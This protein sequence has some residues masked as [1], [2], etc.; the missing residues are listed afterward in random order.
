VI[1][2]DLINEVLI[3]LREDTITVDWSGH[4][5]TPSSGITAYQKVI[6]SLINDAKRNA[7]T[8]HDWFILRDTID[9]STVSTTRSY[10]LGSG[11]ELK[12]LDVICQET[13]SPLTQVSRKYMNSVKYPTAS[14]GDPRYYAFD[15]SDASNNLKVEFDPTPDSVQTISFDVVKYQDDLKS[16][17]DVVKIP[18]R[19]VIL[20]A[21]ARAIAER[22]EDGG[23]ISSAVAAEAREALVM[24]I[25][26]D[27]SNASFE[28]DWVVT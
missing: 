5:N 24:A 28:R 3:R 25:Q 10:S 4:I 14:S 17:S 8:Y 26:V 9:L 2:K 7:E 18:E 15:G 19:I 1:F 16:Y 20:G 21:W 23:T 13:G 27:A 12:L 6:G 22:G 11:Q